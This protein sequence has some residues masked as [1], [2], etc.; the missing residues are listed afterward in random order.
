MEWSVLWF[1]CWTFEPTIYWLLVL[2]FVSG[3][4]YLCHLQPSFHNLSYLLICQLN[5]YLRGTIAGHVG[6]VT[7]FISKPAI[8]IL[9]TKANNKSSTNSPIFI[10]NYPTNFK[11]RTLCNASNAHACPN[12]PSQ[13]NQK[14]QKA[15]FNQNS[16]FLKHQNSHC[17]SHDSVY[18]SHLYLQ[19]WQHPQYELLQIFS[20]LCPYNRR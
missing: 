5:V 7:A 1:I 13:R 6:L 4:W 3:I 8:A 10:T 20:V 14:K 19:E 18:S 9:Q 12:S 16:F 2:K 17:T 11:K 15:K